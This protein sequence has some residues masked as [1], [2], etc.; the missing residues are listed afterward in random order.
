MPQL[1]PA[2]L[3]ERASTVPIVDVRGRTEWD[4]GHLPTAK[5]I[6]LGTLPAA[7]AQLPAGELVVQCQSGGRSAIAASL[8]ARA[9]YFAGR[10]PSV[11]NLVGGYLSWRGAGL[12]T[13]VGSSMISG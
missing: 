6:P 4:A 2:Q 10:T 1:T 9:A 5:H 7:L 8:L 13:V 12:P 3:N 11:V